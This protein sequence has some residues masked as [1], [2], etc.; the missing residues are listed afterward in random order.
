MNKFVVTPSAPEAA[1]QQRLLFWRGRIEELDRA[2]VIISNGRLIV[3][4]AFAV[5]LWMAAVR[6]TASI[7]WPIL[8]ALTFGVLV[9]V[10]A[11]V[12][13]RVDRARRAERMYV[14]G[15]D[16][17]S[18]RWMGTGRNG[19]GFL[20]EH[21]Y[22]RDL[23]IFGRGSVFELLN[24]A[25]TEA[26]EAVLAG[27]LSAGAPIE[28]V[29][30]RQ[31]AVAELRDRPGFREDIGV[32]AAETEVS[33]TGALATW[34]LKSAAG[35]TSVAASTFGVCGLVTI[36]LV[37]LVFQ[38]L[39]AARWL[40]LWLGVEAGVVFAWRAKVRQ[41]LSGIAMPDRDLSLLVDLVARIEVEPLA[42]PR[43]STLRSSL[44]TEGLPPSRRI[45]ELRRLVSWL[46]STRNQLFMPIAFALLL[47]QLLAAAIDRWHSRYGRAVVEWL[48]VVGELEA[49]SALGTYAFEH[50]LDPFPALSEAGPLF[51]AEGLGHPLMSEAVVVRNDVLLGGAA[52][53]RL[54]VIS[55]SNM[56]GK[57][58][59]LRAVGVNVVLGL[60][61]APVR[62]TRLALSPLVIG[63]TLRVEDSLQEGRSRFYAEI[64]RIH[65][66]VASARGSVPLLFLL[67]EILHGTNSY[68]RR[69]GADAIVRALVNDGAIGLITTHDLALTELPAALGPRAANTHFE[70]RLEN[71]KMVFDYK[72]RPGVVEHSNALALMRAIG[73]NV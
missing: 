63:A 54:M 8:L 33:A 1:Y 44:F 55:G 46:D 34:G 31:A 45:A 30:A 58:T 21:P 25:R 60:S 15:L 6:G 35:L 16:R 49:L 3:A 64:L 32:L 23:D 53:P 73:L 10:H 29:K 9:V 57:S 19:A 18:G 28:E 66:I 41:V 59:L 71:G 4:A 38:D 47:P 62:A 36:V 17:L 69:I 7:V 20:G 27:W 13:N 43:L 52:A 50:P 12:L 48:R 5:L 42:T 56:S 37:W 61:G 67:D 65:G 68:D 11:R 51:D 22:A 39:L 40:V 14:R 2:H 26:G 72:M 70:D 24:T